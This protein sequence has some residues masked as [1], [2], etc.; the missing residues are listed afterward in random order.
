[1]S[2]NAGRFDG[3]AEAYDRWRPDYLVALFEALFARAPAAP[4]HAVDVAAGT[5]ISTAGLLAAAPADWRVTAIE[6]GADMRRALTARFADAP[7]VAVVDGLAEALP[8]P[9]GSA[10]VLTAATAFHWFDAP[11]FFA[12]AAR[13]LAPGGVLALLRNRRVAQPVIAAFDAWRAAHCPEDLDP[14]K[15]AV[16][17]EADALAG[18]PGFEAFERVAMRWTCPLA[19]DALIATYL[20]RSTMNA[21]VAAEGAEAVRAALE[22]LYAAHLGDGPIALEYDSTLLSARRR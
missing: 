2:A 21:I 18:A 12:E 6:P 20:T 11:R 3:L 5:G 15:E 14:V 13:V 16:L 10:A 8:P 19:R 4:A 9:D 1:M 7:R 17:G 22:A